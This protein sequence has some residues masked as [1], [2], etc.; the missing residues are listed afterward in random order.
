MASIKIDLIIDET[1]DA[2]ITDYDFL[3]WNKNGKDYSNKTAE[4]LFPQIFIPL[5]ERTKWTPAKINSYYV[6]ASLSINLYLR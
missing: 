1:G 6:K 5:I 2:K 4:S 3:F